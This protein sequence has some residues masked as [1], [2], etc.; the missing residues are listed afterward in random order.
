MHKCVVWDTS[1]SKKIP[2]F[3]QSLHL[4]C[5]SSKAKPRLK[6]AHMWSCSSNN[7]SSFGYCSFTQN[8]IPRSPLSITDL[9]ISYQY[10]HDYA[11]RKFS[12]WF[13]FYTFS[14]DQQGVRYIG[15]HLQF[16]TFQ[17]SPLFTSSVCMKTS[18]RQM[19]YPRQIFNC[20]SPLNRS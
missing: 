17:F 8:S 13:I 4:L 7:S 2:V 3:F 18:G 15:T 1:Y 20:L 11:H 9:L 19:F 12:F 10:F 5:H 6:F 14:E 16:W